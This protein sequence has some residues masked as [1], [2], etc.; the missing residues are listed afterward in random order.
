[1]LVRIGE[2]FLRRDRHGGEG[3]VQ[4]AHIVVE[5]KQIC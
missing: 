4:V 1:M 5:V 2:G 3:I